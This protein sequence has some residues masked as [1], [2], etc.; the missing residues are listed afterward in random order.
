MPNQLYKPFTEQTL[1]ELP[2]SKYYILVRNGKFLDVVFYSIDGGFYK[3][4]T[5][6]LIPSSSLLEVYEDELVQIV[7]IED[8]I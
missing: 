2:R 8:I 4:A 5:S 1:R 3:I 7:S 6:K